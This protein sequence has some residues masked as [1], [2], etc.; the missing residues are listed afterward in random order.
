MDG[1]LKINW[2]QQ[3]EIKNLLSLIACE[4]KFESYRA[5][6]FNIALYTCRLIAP[7]WHSKNELVV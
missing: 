6:Y 1:N 5:P 3:V 7:T 4:L 2:S